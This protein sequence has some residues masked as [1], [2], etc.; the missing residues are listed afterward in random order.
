MSMRFD[1]EDYISVKE[2][3]QNFYRDYPLGVIIPELVSAPDKATEF[4]MFKAKV[5]KERTAAQYNL[6]PDAVGYSLSMAGGRQADKFAWTENCEESA[7]GRALDNM[8]YATSNKCSRDEMEKLQYMKDRE[9]EVASRQESK[10]K[11]EVTKPKQASTSIQPTSQPSK[12]EVKPEVKE[13]EETVPMIKE[14]QVEG[15]KKSVNLLATRGN[16]DM[17]VESFLTENMKLDKKVEDLTFKEAVACMKTLN[18]LM[19]ELASS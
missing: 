14:G 16:T 19:Q 6:P 15:I 9:Q 11:Q 7:I 18:Q 4:V 5:W 10:P 3:K 8:G 12:P 13:Q 1:L 17:T 2:R